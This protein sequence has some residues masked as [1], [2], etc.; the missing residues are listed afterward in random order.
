ML[1]PPPT[2]L[3]RLPQGE[4]PALAL[5]AAQWPQWNTDFFLRGFPL[6]GSHELRL[7]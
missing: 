3:V 4:I 1:S 2:A 6:S 5:S 7:S